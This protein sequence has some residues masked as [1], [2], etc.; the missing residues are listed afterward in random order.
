MSKRN[1]G[2]GSAV[3]EVMKEEVIKVVG[4]GGEG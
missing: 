4:K 1:T 3:V 2:E